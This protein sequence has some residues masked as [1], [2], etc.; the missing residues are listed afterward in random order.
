MMGDRFCLKW[1]IAL[2]AALPEMTAPPAPPWISYRRRSHFQS[3]EDQA[4]EGTAEARAIAFPA[5]H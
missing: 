4:D 3:C 1:V 5:L 2:T